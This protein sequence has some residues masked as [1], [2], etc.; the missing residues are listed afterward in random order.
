M[1]IFRWRE[2]PLLIALALVIVLFFCDDLCAQSTISEQEPLHFHFGALALL[3]HQKSSKLVPL[4]SNSAL[5]TGDRIKFFLE[6]STAGFFY[7]LHHGPDGALS[8]LYPLNLKKTKMPAGERAE[9]PE[10][11]LWFELDTVT[12]VEKFFLLASSSRLLRLEELWARHTNLKDRFELSSS[13]RS[14]MA[15]IA[16]L[17]KQSSSLAAAAEKPVRLAGKVRTLTQ[18]DPIVLPENNTFAEEITAQGFYGKTF[19]IEHR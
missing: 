17:N 7:I 10:G 14:L 18:A 8:L 1:A 9:I 11:T 2:R 3:V 12:G 5:T 13:T 16:R 15:E 19:T 4:A 6:T